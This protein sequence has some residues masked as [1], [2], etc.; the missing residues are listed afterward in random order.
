MEKDKKEENFGYVYIFTN[1]SF[2][3]NWIKVGSA[4]NVDERLKR[5]YTTPVPLPFE[6]YATLKTR[7]YEQ[8]EK[9]L[10]KIFD[11]LA[12]KRVNKRREFFNILPEDALEYLKDQADLLEDGILEIS[13]EE[14]STKNIK[15]ANK[16]RSKY[17]GKYK[18]E[19]N[20]IFY[21]KEAKM[22]VIDK[23]FVV[24]EGSKIIAEITSN[25]KGVINHRKKHKYNLCENL[26]TK[27]TEFYS[28]SGASCFIGG[29]SSD[30]KTDWKTEKGEELE[31]FLKYL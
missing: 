4:K 16:Q 30:G 17:K 15:S 3:D 5:L 1:P 12:K 2:K 21:F 9:Y 22:K 20:K 31:K 6:R 26:V 28:P 23:K 7:K 10:I 18:V 8:V 19:T 13:G 24:L 11:N 27:N 25:H 14:K 29:R